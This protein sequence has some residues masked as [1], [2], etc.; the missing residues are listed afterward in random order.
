MLLKRSCAAFLQKELQLPIYMN[1]KMLD[2][3]KEKPD[4]PM[5]HKLFWGKRSPFQARTIGE[6]FSYSCNM[7]CD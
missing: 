4:Y 3:C 7:G 1:D 2:Y 5:Y 6:T